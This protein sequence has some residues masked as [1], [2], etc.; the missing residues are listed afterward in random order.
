[1]QLHCPVC[2]ECLEAKDACFGG[3]ACPCCAH[4]SV[5][6]SCMGARSRAERAALPLGAPPE[7]VTLSEDAVSFRC[8]I[9]KSDIIG[10]VVLWLTAAAI[11]VA[12]LIF[13]HER[14]LSPS[15]FWT[16][17]GIFAVLMASLV[18]S[19]AYFTFAADSVI[20]TAET[21]EFRNGFRRWAR[22]RV[23][24]RDAVRRIVLDRQLVSDGEGRSGPEFSLRCEFVDGQPDFRFAAGRSYVRLA[25]VA[26]YLE[27]AA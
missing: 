26:R 9:V 20:G 24:R 5:S 16:C 13:F 2:G 17:F 3:Y 4:I 10:P 6:R 25:W 11:M 8:D 12:A 27:E 18:G 7:G 22:R 14:N 23:V 21:L 15:D 19:A 1:M